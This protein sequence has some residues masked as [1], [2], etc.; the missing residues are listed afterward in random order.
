MSR[1]Y[2]HHAQKHIKRRFEVWSKRCRLV[3]MWSYSAL[4][5]R[6][7]H[8]YERREGKRAVAAQMTERAP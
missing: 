5:K 3:A 4:M 2:H 8:R 1:T 6:I 7:T